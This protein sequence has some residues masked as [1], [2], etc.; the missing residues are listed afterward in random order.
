M[1]AE[2]LLRSGGLVP[3]PSGDVEGIA[4]NMPAKDRRKPTEGGAKYGCWLS[5]AR[6]IK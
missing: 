1:V 6:E 5:V 4:V 2:A 3:D